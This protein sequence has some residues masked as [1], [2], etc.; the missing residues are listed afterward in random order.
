MTPS[1]QDLGTPSAPP[2]IENG[3]GESDMDVEGTVL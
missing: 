1:L 2:I 3:G